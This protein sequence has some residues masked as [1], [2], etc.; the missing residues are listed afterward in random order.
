M[1]DK[2][3]SIRH[4]PGG[5][6]TDYD[7]APYLRDAGNTY[8]VRRVSDGVV[9]LAPTALTADGT[10]QYSI[11]VTGLA[12]DG[13]EYEYALERTYLGQLRRTVRQFTVT[14]GGASGFWTTQD[15]DLNND[16]SSTATVWQRAIDWVDALVD[17]IFTQA[18]YERPTDLTLTDYVL[19]S[20]Y[21]AAIARNELHKGRGQTET[22]GA[23]GPAAGGVYQKEADEA[24]AALRQMAEQGVDFPARTEDDGSASRVLPQSIAPDRDPMGHLVSTSLNPRPYLQPYGFGCGNAWGW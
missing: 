14:A 1:A 5:V 20:G 21:A 6:L 3:I 13:T 18:G 24:E 22:N 10:G 15:V 17:R 11:T 9:M 7:A 16:N 12:A 4:A 2:T 8:G 23:G 19:A